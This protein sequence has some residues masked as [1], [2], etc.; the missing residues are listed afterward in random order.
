M[1]NFEAI[2]TFNIRSLEADLIDLG[3]RRAFAHQVNHLVDGIGIAFEMRLNR[4]VPAITDPT[5]E[6]ECLCLVTRP[7]TEEHALDSAAHSYVTG[8]G[9][10]TVAMS[11]ASSAFIP[12]TL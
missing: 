3:I 7:G 12:T 10:H 8:Y 2:L 11:G 6:S 9:H 1:A 4:P 5:R